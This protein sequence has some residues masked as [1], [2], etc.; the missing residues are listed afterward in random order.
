MPWGR[1]SGYHNLRNQEMDERASEGF[2]AWARRQFDTLL[3]SS[4]GPAAETILYT[5]AIDDQLAGRIPARAEQP[6]SFAAGN[7]VEGPSR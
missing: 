7:L 6:G 4:G 3:K 2:F 5:H 1:Q